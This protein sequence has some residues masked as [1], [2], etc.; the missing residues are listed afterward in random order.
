MRSL[1]TLVLLLVPVLAGCG[2]GNIGDLFSIFPPEAFQPGDGGDGDGGGPPLP[3]QPADIGGLGGSDGVSGDV[4]NIVLAQVGAGTYAFLAAGP[5]GVHV[6]NV[7]NPDL[8]NRGDYVTTIQDGV[9]TDP[10]A[11]LAGGRVDALAVV[12]NAFL[13]CVAVGTAATNAVTVFGLVEL[14]ARATDPSAD[15]SPAFIPLE[16]AN[17]G[18]AVSGT[19]DGK[20]GGVSGAN[21]TF[22]VATGGPE[23]GIGVI[24]PGTPSWAAAPPFDPT[25][26]E[27]DNFLDVRVLPPLSIVTSVK[28]GTTYG[29]LSLALANP[30][31][32]ALPQII[33]VADADDNFDNVAADFISGPGN[34]PLDLASDGITNIYVSGDNDVKVLAVT[35]TV[36]NPIAG[37]GS[38]TI[39]VDASTGLVAVGAGDAVRVYSYLAGRAQQTAAVSFPGTFTIRGVA[40]LTT[41]QGSFVICCAGSG[42]MRVVQLTQTQQL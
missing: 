5:N 20:A 6:V 19:A 23:L 40:L 25:V 41:D 7:T 30:P 10:A 26:P 32:P 33:D 35:L 42:G 18:I 39:A 38:D 22:F 15:L 13:V 16:A 28:R 36:Q 12:D 31:V 14:I 1:Y 3:F 34:H 37:T 9:L 29:L 24:T 27:V 21:G 8:V 2:G 4:R 17:P 11:S